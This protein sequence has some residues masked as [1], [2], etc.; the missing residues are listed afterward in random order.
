M[1][2]PWS[3][4][5]QAQLEDKGRVLDTGGRSENLHS[6]CQDFQPSS[7][8]S[9]YKHGCQA[10]TYKQETVRAFP[11][12]FQQHKRKHLKTLISRFSNNTLQWSPQ[13]TSP[14]GKLRASRQH[15]SAPLLI[16]AETRVYRHLK[17]I[18]NIKDGNQIKQDKRK[19]TKTM[20]GKHFI[21]RIY[22]ISWAI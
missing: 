22:L 7:P 2:T 16:G 4:G 3:R 1:E 19:L 6:K 5:H 14:S 18:A 20:Q 15:L 21:F 17:K 9:F 11:G 12:G 13:V 10:Y 8:L